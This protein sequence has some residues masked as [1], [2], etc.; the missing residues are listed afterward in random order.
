MVWFRKKLRFYILVKRGE[1]A[2]FGK[3][4]NLEGKKKEEMKRR[5]WRER[6]GEEAR[7]KVEENSLT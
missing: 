3:G 7:R 1:L 6:I 4:E 2:I 5:S